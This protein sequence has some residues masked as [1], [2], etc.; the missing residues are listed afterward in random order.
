MKTIGWIGLGQ[1]GSIMALNVTKAGY[2]VNVFN[3]T[4]QKATPL[5]DLGA[6]VM[7]SSKDVVAN[8]DV[9]VLMLTNAE[10]IRAALHGEDG[11]LAGVSPGHTIIDMSTI[12]PQESEEFAK[13][14]ESKGGKYLD[15]PVSGS[16]GAAAVAGLIILA[17]ATEQELVE[18][19]PVFATLGKK[20]IPFGS[21]GKGSAAKLV[22]N[23]LLAI[24]SQAIGETMLFAEKLGLDQASVIDLI[25]NSGMNTPLFQTKKDMFRSQEFPSQF[26]LE[27]MAKDLGLI[28]NA[29]DAVGLQLPLAQ[30]VDS[31]FAGA[32]DNGKGKLDLAAIYLELKERQTTD[33]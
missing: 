12:A 4:P 19:I 5:A 8:S 32:R 1:M 22:I 21:I 29:I 25:S 16:I 30:I 26:M 9:T 20:V 7:T 17:G 10:A 6:R 23:L 15:A 31:T 24:F 13:L 18:F 2:A 3:R 14:V 11:V 33:V 27:L 28:S